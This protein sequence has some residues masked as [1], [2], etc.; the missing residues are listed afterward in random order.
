MTK[1]DMARAL[2]DLDPPGD[3]T[4]ATFAMHVAR[5]RDALEE[6]ALTA[7]ERLEQMTRERD[8]ARAQL[9]ALAESDALRERT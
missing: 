1:Q 3:G 5:E 4:W 7:E 9:A 8:E 2:S 6:R